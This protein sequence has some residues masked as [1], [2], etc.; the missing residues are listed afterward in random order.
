[1]GG[2]IGFAATANDTVP[3]CMI[4]DA[5]LLPLVVFG[6]QFFA[7]GVNNF[8]TLSVIVHIKSAE[9]IVD[10]VVLDWDLSRC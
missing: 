8:S 6:G 9:G 4:G 1:M 2:M 10:R 5:H 3:F 7:A